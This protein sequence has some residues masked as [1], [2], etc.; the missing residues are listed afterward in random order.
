MKKVKQ[1]NKNERTKSD[2]DREGERVKFITPS[3]KLSRLPISLAQLKQEIIQKNLKMKSD[4]YC[5]LYT[6]QK[7]LQSK[8]IKVLLTLFKT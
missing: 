2:K 5:I 3:Q 1:K 7:N 4:N 8:S 6:D